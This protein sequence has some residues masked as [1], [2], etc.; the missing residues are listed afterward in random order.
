ML[1]NPEE[2]D[3]NG[4]RK[5]RNRARANVQ[6]WVYG[7]TRDV[8]HD[9]YI[10]LL[11]ET[12]ERPIATTVPTDEKYPTYWLSEVIEPNREAQTYAQYETMARLYVI[13][14]LGRSDWTG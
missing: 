7:K 6:R 11:N 14:A 8:V 12:K 9:K 3:D 10:K 1:G 5:R 2:P 13:P 4:N